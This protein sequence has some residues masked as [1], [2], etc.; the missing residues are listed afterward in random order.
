MDCPWRYPRFLTAFRVLEP[1]LGHKEGTIDSSVTLGSGVA[2]KHP[3]LAVG[4][5]A[6]GAAVLAGY[7][8]GMFPLFHKPSLIHHQDPMRVPHSVTTYRRKSFRTA[9]LS[10]AY[11]SRTRS[12]P[13]GGPSS[14]CSASCHPFLRSTSA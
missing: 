3:H 11:R 5:L 1:L 7:P 6:Q 12:L 9:R 13:R 10:Q 4:D 2:Q 14:A 8:H